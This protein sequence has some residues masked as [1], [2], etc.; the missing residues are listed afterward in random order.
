MSVET[1]TPPQ[2][3][4]PEAA[5]PAKGA[6]LFLL[7]WGG[8]LIV[9]GLMAMG[10]A[11]IATLTSVVFLGVLLLCG[12]AVQVGSA[13]A[14]GGKGFWCHMLAG[15]LCAI[16]GFFVVQHPLAAAAGLTLMIAAAFLFGGALRIVM[17]LKERF[18]GWG[19]VLANGVVTFILGVMLWRRWPE[20]AL[21]VIGLFVGIDLF[22]AG[23]SWI[24]LAVAARSVARPTA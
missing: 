19:F 3:M 6:W 7:L 8:L 13:I 17:A 16:V 11:V 10:S 12:G 9:V 14:T 23:V 1:R 24:M 4:S 5:A 2:P 15:I 18:P 22:L 21:W 20:D